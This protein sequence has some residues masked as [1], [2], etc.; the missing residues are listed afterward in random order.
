MLTP[1]G[2]LMKTSQK[3]SF[4]KLF[5]TIE[6][7]I[8]NLKTLGMLFKNE[9]K[10][11]ATLENINFYRLSGVWFIF[12][13]EGKFKDN[14]YLED[15]LNIYNFDR[16]FRLHMPNATERIE[17]SIRNRFITELSSK[18]G[19]FAHLDITIFHNQQRHSFLISK[20]K[21]DFKRSKELFSKH[22]KTKYKEEL[23]PLWISAELMTMGQISNWL[24]NIKK[25]QDRQS[26]AKYYNL[27]EK[28]LL[29]FLH[30]LTVVRNISAHHSRL[31]NKKL[32]IS[33]IYP[34]ILHNKMNMNN[35]QN[36]YNTIVM[37][38]Y[39]MDIIETDNIW[40]DRLEELLI[41]YHIDKTMMGYK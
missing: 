1:R 22:F 27:D 21:E 16:E 40:K 6:E 41:K 14:I 30:N 24:N 33:F 3:Q 15:I 38:E 28:V 18:Y 13:K 25:R 23:P 5:L 8:L 31:W 11:K 20:L 37:C 10:A 26:I 17:I 4:N 39:L 29:S 7:Q 32:P 35:K 12:K 9:E 2:R 19:L 36:I 34:K